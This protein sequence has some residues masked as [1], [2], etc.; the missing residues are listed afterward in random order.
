MTAYYLMRNKDRL[1]WMQRDMD[2][3]AIDVIRKWPCDRVGASEGR[4]NSELAPRQGVGP[5]SVSNRLY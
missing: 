3:L 4:L 1:S 2:R 5:K